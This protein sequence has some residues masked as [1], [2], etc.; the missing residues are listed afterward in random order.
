MNTYI[1]SHT[2]LHFKDFD[3]DRQAVIARA[4]DAGVRQI[5]SLGTDVASSKRTLEISREYPTV[6]A[7]TGIHP[8]EAHLAE[9]NAVTEIEALAQSSTQVVAIGE[10]G[11]DFYWDK[12]HHK[13]QYAMFGKMLRLAEKLKLP[14]VIHNRSAQRE[15]EWF[16]Q[17]EQFQTVDG[18]MHCFAGDVI[19][20]R[21][22]LDM[23]LHIS[24]TANITYQNFSALDV[25]RY[26]PLD[27]LLL[28]TDSPYIPP[29]QFRKQRNEPAHVVH[30]AEKLA[31]IHG[32]SVA[33][34][35][36]ITTENTRRLFRLPEVLAV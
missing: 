15:M 21:F 14:V 25:V 6:F 33:E 32:K 7:A 12:T 24:F 28:E 36:A 10:I 22:Y 16:F 18:V 23:G 3:N 13:A 8:S 5:I 9:K 20:T 1:D 19:D 4:F 35:A 31:E 30:V 26:V 2:H 27:R 29:R 17:E 11:L 34:I